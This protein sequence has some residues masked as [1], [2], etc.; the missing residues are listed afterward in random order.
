MVKVCD[1]DAVAHWMIEDGCNDDI[2]C[3]AS[4]AETCHQCFNQLGPWHFLRC[5]VSEQN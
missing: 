2:Q 4:Q 3:S 1:D 5:S